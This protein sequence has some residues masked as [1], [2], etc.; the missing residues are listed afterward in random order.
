MFLDGVRDLII[1]NFITLLWL[2]GIMK[3]MK[4]FPQ[5]DH[6]SAVCKAISETITWR[7]GR[8]EICARQLG[9]GKNCRSSQTRAPRD[10]PLFAKSGRQTS[11]VKKAGTPP[12]YQSSSVKIH[13]ADS[14][15]ALTCTW[16]RFMCWMQKHTI[17]LSELALAIMSHR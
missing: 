5:F 15:P 6:L 14:G 8:T 13:D 16:Q 12:L 7:R 10:G 4:R 3:W 11:P 2:G 17:S 9:T 1:K